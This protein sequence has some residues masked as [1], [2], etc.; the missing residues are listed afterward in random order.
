M[1]VHPL[2][3]VNTGLFVPPNANAGALP[4]KLMV[5]VL[6]ID[7]VPLAMVIAVLKVRVPVVAVITALA[8][9]VLLP[10]VTEPV[11]NSEPLV[12][13]IWAIWPPAAAWLPGKFKLPA[14]IHKPAFT[15]KLLVWP[16]VGWFMVNHY[17]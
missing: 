1:T 6:V 8:A 15:S 12:T 9:W 14:T 17:R 10:Q 3:V 13:V 2:V 11:T 16:P 7:R 4:L 5:P